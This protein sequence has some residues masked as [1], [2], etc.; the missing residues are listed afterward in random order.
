MMRLGLFYLRGLS[1]KKDLKMARLWFEKGAELGDK[2]SLAQL[3][4]M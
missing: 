2:D 3:R 4:T 1:I